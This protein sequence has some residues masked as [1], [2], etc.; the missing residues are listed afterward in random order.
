MHAQSF[1]NQ[2][3][4]A[5]TKRNQLASDGRFLH[6]FRNHSY[7][8]AVPLPLPAMNDDHDLAGSSP[9]ATSFDDGPYPALKT[10]LLSRGVPRHKQTAEV[11]GLLGLAKTSV[12]RKFK[13]E[14]SFSLPELKVIADH[15]ATDVDTLRGLAPGHA[16]RG[17][18]GASTEAA[19]LHLPGLPPQGQLQPGPALADDDVC[20]LVAVRIGEQ[21][22]VH[23]GSSP[24]VRG[25]V[26]H[27][28]VSLRLASAP[29]PRVALLEDDDN[30]AA[31]VAMALEGEGMV[32][33]THKTSA[34]LSAS[35]ARRP[36]QGY[37]IDWLLGAGTAEAAIRQIRAGQPSAPIAITTGALHT[38]AETE[39]SLIPFA[40]Q[41]SVGIFEKP[42]RQAVLASYLR[43]GMTEPSPR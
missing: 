31:V 25:Q 43:R 4:A 42:F 8:P 27:S 3:A 10:F 11:A 24:E 18:G 38:G 13:G 22:H 14:S 7:N 2:I 15:F 39:G 6:F 23:A 40:E 30:A 29:R 35:L 17:P 16:D 5:D 28:I 19:R 26:R 36:F 1:R 20:D 41:F 34:D 9:D 32:V 33:Q 12:F 21:W 37:V